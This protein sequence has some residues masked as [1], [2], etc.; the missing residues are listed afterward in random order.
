MKYPTS[1]T[2]N[3]FNRKRERESKRNKHHKNWKKTL[4]YVD[5]KQKKDDI[6]DS[7]PVKMDSVVLIR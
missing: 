4:E 2:L 5:N 7:C 6:S 1:I 3:L